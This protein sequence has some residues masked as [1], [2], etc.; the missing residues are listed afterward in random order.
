M[1]KLSVQLIFIAYVDSNLFCESLSS[2]WTLS[3]A[4]IEIN[5]LSKLIFP[6]CVLQQV[7]IWQTYEHNL[8]GIMYCHACLQT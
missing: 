4:F 2:G 8:L 7:Y 1:A 5:G 6:C 3:A